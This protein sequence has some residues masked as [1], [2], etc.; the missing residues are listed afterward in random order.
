M[1]QVPKSSSPDFDLSLREVQRGCDLDPPWPAE[2]LVEVELLLEFQELSVG[3]RRAKP[4]GKTVVRHWKES[5]NR[6][7]GFLAKKSSIG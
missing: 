7:E 1:T 3:V 5:R 4:T 6:F 2:V